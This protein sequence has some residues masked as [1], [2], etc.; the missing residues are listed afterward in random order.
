MCYNKVVEEQTMKRIDMTIDFKSDVETVFKTI[1]TLLDCSWRS[2]LLKVE[3]IDDN[4]FIEYNRKHKK[5]KIYVTDFRKNIQ[6]DYN[7]ENNSY[8]GHWSGQFAPLDDGGCRM[9]LTFDFEPQSMLGK[10]ARV[11]KFEERYIE[12]LKKKLQEY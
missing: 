7:V 8:K 9:F 6:F 4:K 3:Q 2:D 11:D 1:T 12:D 10:F 5:T